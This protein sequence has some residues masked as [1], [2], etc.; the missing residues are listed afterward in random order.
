MTQNLTRLKR[1]LLG[2]K[3]LYIPEDEVKRWI[4]N[5]SHI[6]LSLKQKTA[7]NAEFYVNENKNHI[8]WYS[9]L[10]EVFFNIDNQVLCCGDLIKKNGTKS[11][12]C[13]IEIDEFIEYVKDKTF[14]VSVNPEG[15]VA[16]FRKG[17][18]ITSELINTIKQSITM[19]DYKTVSKYLALSTEYTLTEI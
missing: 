5:N 4:D 7:A 16:K 3:Q 9:Q 12:I 2:S 15:D 1:Y 14:R 13:D 10:S 11:L 6:R 17:F 19:G 8:I 18:E